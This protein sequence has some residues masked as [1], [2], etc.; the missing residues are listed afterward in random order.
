MNFETFNGF[1]NLL[2]EFI[3]R[4]F[5]VAWRAEFVHLETRNSSQKENIFGLAINQRKLKRMFSFEENWL[6]SSRWRCSE[7]HN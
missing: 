3:G 6:D 1:R 5:S 7:L 2:K 4:K